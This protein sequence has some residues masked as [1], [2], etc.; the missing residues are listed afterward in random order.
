MW[1]KRRLLKVTLS[2]VIG[3]GNGTILRQRK[4]KELQ[5]INI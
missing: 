1:N 5:E 4:K 3:I 2:M